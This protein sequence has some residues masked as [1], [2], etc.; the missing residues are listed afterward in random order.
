MKH[1]SPDPGHRSAT[2]P[3]G[4]QSARY[5]SSIAKVASS[6]VS[7]RAVADRRATA[8]VVC[9]AAARRTPAFA[10]HLTLRRAGDGVSLCAK[11]ST[12]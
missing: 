3:I 1:G 8:E 9:R 6:A 12:S 7:S 5:P 10:R 4:Q 11:L 2:T